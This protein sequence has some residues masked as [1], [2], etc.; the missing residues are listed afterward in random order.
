MSQSYP[1]VYPVRRPVSLK[2]NKGPDNLFI[3]QIYLHKIEN[4]EEASWLKI[5]SLLDFFWLTSIDNRNYQNTK[6]IW[7]TL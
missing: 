7:E 3:T 1:R 6:E 5:E 2:E 4:R